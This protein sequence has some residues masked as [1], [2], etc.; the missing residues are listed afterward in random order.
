LLR[1][2]SAQ[3]GK[4]ILQDLQRSSYTQTFLHDAKALT[5]NWSWVVAELERLTCLGTFS[6]PNKHKG[7]WFIIAIAQDWA[8]AYQAY[9][10]NH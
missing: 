1:S 9:P 10:Q 7:V 4:T 3:N 6:S 5:I 8:V 2:T